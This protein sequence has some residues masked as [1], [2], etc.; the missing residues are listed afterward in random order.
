M[1]GFADPLVSPEREGEVRE[2]AGNLDPWEGVLDLAA[3]LDKGDAVA[4]VFL[5]PGSN[6]EDIGIENDILR[7]KA[8]FPGQYPVGAGADVD[9]T[10]DGIRLP[11]L[12]ERHD[13]DGGTIAKHFSGLL[14]EGLF[15][16]FKADR[17]YDGF[18][19]YAS[20]AGLDHGPFRGIDHDRHAADVRLRCDKLEELRHRGFGIEHGFVHVDVD[21]LCAILDLLAG[22]FERRLEIAFHDQF[23]EPGGAGDIRALADID[24]AGDVVEMQRLE[25]GKSAE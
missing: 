20:E 9:F 23:L 4:V 6:G 22:D 19:L 5:D 12:V 25:A 17:V 1:H 16:F 2:A 10:F 7:G 24:E 18:A 11:L 13:D 8:D 14:A 15:A 3:R 21:D